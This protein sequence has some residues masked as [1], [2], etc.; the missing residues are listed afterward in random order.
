MA[1]YDG[2]CGSWVPTAAGRPV[3]WIGTRHVCHRPHHPGDTTHW[4]ADRLWTWQTG[5]H[6]AT[7]TTPA[8]IANAPTRV[9]A[10]NENGGP[11]PNPTDETTA[12]TLTNHE[13]RQLV[14]A[15]Y[16]RGY[17]SG[18]ADNVA[19]RHLDGLDAVADLIIN[20]RR[21]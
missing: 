13:I 21:I 6:L 11:P 4:T 19:E 1:R 8:D 16:T 17:R 2:V 3:A 18:T 14:R 12:R 5:A 7:P 10:A 9:N 20:A 15:T